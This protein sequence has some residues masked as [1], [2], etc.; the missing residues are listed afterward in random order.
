MTNNVHTGIPPVLRR[1][2]SPAAVRLTAL[3]A[4]FEDLQTALRCCERLVSELTAPSTPVGRGGEG[5]HPLRAGPPD[6]VLVEALWTLALLSYARCFRLGIDPETGSGLTEDDVAATHPE[7]EV[8]EWHAVLLRLRDH[9]A[10]VAVNPREQFSV[11]VAQDTVGRASG[12]AVTSNRQPLVDDVTVRQMGAIAYALS[13]VVDTRIAKAQSTL[14][15]N[16]KDV[17][18]RDLDK[19]EPLEVA[20][21]DPA[22]GD[23]VQTGPQS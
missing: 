19:L 18:G 16:V 22:E 3:C 2:A 4:T 14:F 7:S 13:V 1:Y 12:V 5:E 11:G 8:L 17:P 23:R 6:D 15:D 20:A 9:Y 21:S 10:D